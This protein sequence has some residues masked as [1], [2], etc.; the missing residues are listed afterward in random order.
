MAQR[1]ERSGLAP[2]A[3]AGVDGGEGV[4]AGEAVRKGL[5][6]LVGIQRVL[7]TECGTSG[8]IMA[9]KRIVSSWTW[10]SK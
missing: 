9:K 5:R 8:A 10:A 1:A 3:G 4:L 7:A 6:V 2:G